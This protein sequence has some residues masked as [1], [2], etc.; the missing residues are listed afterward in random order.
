MREI[1]FK[2]KR[3]DNREWVEGYY[4][5]KVD[6]FYGTEK[7]FILNQGREGDL[8]SL[9]QWFLVDPETVCQYTELTDKNG[10]K[11]F[12]GD[13]LKFTDNG[14]GTE[15]HGIIL[16]GNPNGEYT[17]GWQIKHLC[18]DEANTDTLLWFD[19]EECLVYSEVTGN[20]HDNTS[21]NTSTDR[22]TDM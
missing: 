19:M 3:T 20:I 1:L 11:V 14:N 22:S 5:K 16:F 21:T 17:W 15:W 10:A 8:T 6:P 4:L 9:F 2:A 13:L 18:G 7:H 12:D